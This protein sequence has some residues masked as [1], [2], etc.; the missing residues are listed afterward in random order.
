MSTEVLDPQA[1]PDVVEVQPPGDL[2]V[3]A[4]NP[5]ELQLAQSQ[6]VS[7]FA[8]KVGA[9][10]AE[11]AIGRQ[12]LENAREA[13]WR[14]AP[15]QKI[16]RDLE[17]N[18][19]YYQK[20]LAAVEEGYCIVPNFPVEIV[21]IRTVY[22]LP[23]KQRCESKHWRPSMESSSEMNE[24]GEGEYVAKDL[25]IAVTDVVKD[26]K[27]NIKERWWEAT[28]FKEVALP[29]KFMKPKVLAATQHAMAHKIFDEVGV[30]PARKKSDPIVVG[31]IL[32]PKEK[33]L[34]FLIAWFVDSRD[35]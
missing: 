35:L 15:F 3:V 4:E 21:A 26:E 28:E 2:L 19:T 17:L 9:I 20:A 10:D 12:E 27:G 7:W 33:V 25:K 22:D 30:L 14:L 32:G 11:L 1:A 29:V 13:G 16:V 8:R 23:G 34:T 6:I 18:Q 24:V 5:G 31:R